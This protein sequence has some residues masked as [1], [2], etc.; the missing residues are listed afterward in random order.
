MIEKKHQRT[1]LRSPMKSN[2]L[3]CQGSNVGRS[4]TLN[5]SQGG[6]LMEEIQGVKVGDILPIMVE[7]PKIPILPLLGEKKIYLLDPL[8]FEREIIRAKI[9]VVRIYKGQSSFKEGE[10]GQM[11]GK[12]FQT[13]K[14]FEREIN[15]Y[16][17]SF[18]KNVVF[19]LNVIADLGQGKRQ[20]P[21]LKHVSFLLG[22]EVQDNIS[23]LR[24]KVL[25]DYQS[26]ENF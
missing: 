13:S 16:V 11:G 10:I 9:E 14:S 23:L 5:I 4:K 3:F 2:F 1:A 12:F 25:H 20:M 24:Q 21:L 17:L 18:K 6:L 8:K 7:L 22:Y 26:L 19:I 15:D